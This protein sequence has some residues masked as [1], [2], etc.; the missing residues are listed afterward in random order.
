[1]QTNLFLIHDCTALSPTVR[2]L[3]LQRKDG[4]CYRAGQYIEISFTDPH[5]IHPAEFFPFSLASA[6]EDPYLE[7]CIRTQEGHILTACLA[8]AQTHDPVWVKGPTGRFLYASP[9]KRP[10]FLIAT[11]TGIAPLR[12]LY[13]SQE[14]EQ[15]DPS[16]IRLLFGARNTS[17]LLYHNEWLDALGDRYTPILSQADE[18]WTGERGRVTALFERW[19]DRFVWRDYDY[20]LCGQSEMLATAKHFL[21]THRVPET[22]I[23]HERW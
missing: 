17:E 11:G 8:A 3:R 15:A 4:F 14:R 5:G 12:A 9:P 6:P 13:R 20:Y 7:M 19:N 21:A 22:H 10:L 16:E 18:T 2:R 23:H 1:M